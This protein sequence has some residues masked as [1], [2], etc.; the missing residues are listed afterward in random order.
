MEVTLE[1]DSLKLK[2]GG[3]LVHTV[4]VK[5]YQC[6]QLVLLMSA[7]VRAPYVGLSAW[8]PFVGKEIIIVHAFIT[9]W[10]LTDTLAT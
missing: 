3:S 10:I 6:N 1:A 8:E 7:T 2:V 9:I 4:K 5:N